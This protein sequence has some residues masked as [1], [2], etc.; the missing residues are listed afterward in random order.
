MVA[1]KVQCETAQLREQTLTCARMTAHRQFL[2]ARRRRRAASLSE[3]VGTAPW[4]LR[5]DELSCFAERAEP[6]QREEAAPGVEHSACEARRL[7][8]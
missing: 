2:K 1:W 5:R 8:W 3:A 4:L 6:P 7:R